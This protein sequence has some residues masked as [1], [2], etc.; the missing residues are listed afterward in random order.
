MEKE[1]LSLL[2]YKLNHPTI[3]HFL[4][5]YHAYFN[6]DEN[7]AILSMVNIILI[8]RNLILLI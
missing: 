6:I 4:K 5:I 3:M 7:V 8:F 2:E 1:I